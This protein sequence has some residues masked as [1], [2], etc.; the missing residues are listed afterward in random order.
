MEMKKILLLVVAFLISGH[1]AINGQSVIEKRNKIESLNYVVNFLNEGDHGMLIVH[2]MLENYNQDINKYV[3]LD[4][5]KINLFSNKD[6]PKDIFE[7]K[8]RWFY[9]TSPY[10]WY[11]K[12]INSLPKS[13]LNGASEI[14][15][16]MSQM[17]KILV[18]VNQIRFNLDDRI[19]GKDLTD[20][21][22]LAKVYDELERGVKLYEDFFTYHQSILKIVG[23]NMQ[24]LQP[25]VNEVKYPELYN[26]L[27]ELYGTTRTILLSIRLKEDENIEQLI[28][29]QKVALKKVQSINT[30]NYGASKLNG[31]NA[32][33]RLKNIISQAKKSIEEAEKFYQTAEVPVEYKQYGKFYYYYNSDIINKFNRYGNGLV[34]ELNELMDELDLPVL[35]FT[36]LPHYYKVIYPRKL[37]KVEYIAATD[38]KITRLPQKLKDREIEMSSRSIKVD[39]L[40]FKLK[41][42]DHMI[43]DGDI[44]SINFNGDWI[45]EK[46]P[47]KSI[48]KELKL[49]LNEEGK[50]YLILHADDVGRRP[51]NTM[52]V[53]YTYRGFNKQIILESDLNVSELI[54]IEYVK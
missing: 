34:F 26:A 40:N 36:E 50:N 39:S 41:L 16:K 24:S 46:M 51:P 12:A 11:Q 13:G 5:Y 48:K 45:V 3:D 52:A 33:R 43:E 29:N 1:S 27:A 2:R 35:R 31:G 17:K 53:D 18:E 37:D 9:D 21:T 30:S 22:L 28:A 14:S 25:T 20:T 47:L 19:H 32:K 7:D 54:E 6:L 42:Y 44:V 23:S 10:E 15:S 8:D 4:S 38:S 49:Q